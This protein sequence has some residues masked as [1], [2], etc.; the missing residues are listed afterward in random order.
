MGVA[1]IGLLLGSLLAGSMDKAQSKEAHEA[2]IRDCPTCARAS[3]LKQRSIAAANYT[4][5]QS[6]SHTQ[7]DTN[8]GGEYEDD[9]IGLDLFETTEEPSVPDK[10]PMS[11]Q[12]QAIHT[13]HMSIDVAGGGDL[14][15]RFA[16]QPLRRSASGEG[17]MPPPIDESTPFLGGT[18]SAP[19]STESK[20]NYSD[21]E[22]R[23][24]GDSSYSSSSTSTEDYSIVN[25]NK[26]MTR[27]KA[28]KYTFLT[29]KQALVNS[30]YIITAGSI[31]F[32]YIESMSAV[33]AFYFTTVL[34]T[35][36]G[37]GDIVPGKNKL[38][39]SWQ[40]LCALL[41]I[42]GRHSTLSHDVLSTKSCLQGM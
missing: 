10:M 19:R 30:L 34:L 40:H 12:K 4:S 39:P 29:L 15:T 26:P 7:N 37:Y 28:A 24:M 3:K 14:L 1:T 38:F 20:A 41:F 35:S 31:G 27:V 25:P 21:V 9:S 13:R 32:Y 17:R 22:M 6:Q 23:S 2:Q 11:A 36:V 42:F 8:P 33:D 16:P 18:A 5:D